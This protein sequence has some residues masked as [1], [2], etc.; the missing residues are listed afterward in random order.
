MARLL[1]GL[2]QSTVFTRHTTRML[3]VP[4]CSN[5]STILNLSH[6]WSELMNWLLYCY[7]Y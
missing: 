2:S 5:L 7:C 4:T 3:N 1:P 6:S